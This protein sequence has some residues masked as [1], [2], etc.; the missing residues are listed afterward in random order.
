MFA[1]EFRNFRA[2]FL[3]SRSNLYLLK[4]DGRL[5]HAIRPLEETRRELK[6]GD[7]WHNPRST[8]P[9]PGIDRWE[10][11]SDQFYLEAID[12]TYRVLEQKHDRTVVEEIR[13]ILCRRNKR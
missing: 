1:V 13:R 3:G 11:V 10:G 8:V 12:E 2:G 4:D 7:V 6:I 5:V 9:S